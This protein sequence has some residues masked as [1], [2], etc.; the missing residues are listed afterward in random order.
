VVGLL[1]P[2]SHSFPTQ[3]ANKHD[4]RERESDWKTHDGRSELLVADKWTERIIE[5]NGPTKPQ[6]DRPAQNHRSDQRDGRKRK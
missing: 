4:G 1:R 3:E 2:F 6:A 5:F